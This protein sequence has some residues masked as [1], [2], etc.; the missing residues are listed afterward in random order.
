ME[1]KLAF[2]AGDIENM[3]VT[4]KCYAVSHTSCAN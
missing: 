2:F 4:Q 3:E 1:S